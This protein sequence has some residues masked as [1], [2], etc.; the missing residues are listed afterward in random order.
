MT[1]HSIDSKR[2]IKQRD[3]VREYL[4]KKANKEMKLKTLQEIISKI[5]YEKY[6]GKK[7]VG[8]DFYKIQEPSSSTI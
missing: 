1:I 6:E 8:Y 7:A 3:K 2:G 5:R 4:T